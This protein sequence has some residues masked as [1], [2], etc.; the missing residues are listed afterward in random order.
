LSLNLFFQ[1]PENKLRLETRQ[2]SE[3]EL[4]IQRSLQRLNVPEW[5]KKH[6]TNSSGNSTSGDG[7]A[8]AENKPG[9]LKILSRRSEYGSAGGLAGGWSGL[10]AFKAPSMSSLQSSNGGGRYSG[11]LYTNDAF[12]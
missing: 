3:H 5:F 7:S 1:P 12:L 2:L 11:K 10:S 9:N 4:R 6:E 8:S